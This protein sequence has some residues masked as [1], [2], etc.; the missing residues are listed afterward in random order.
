MSSLSENDVLET[1]FP[2]SVPVSPRT[3]TTSSTPARSQSPTPSSSSSSLS[4]YKNLAKLKKRVTSALFAT[5]STYNASSRSSS[6]LPS[7]TS[8]ASSP[9]ARSFSNASRLSATTTSAS[10]SGTATRVSRPRSQTLS[11]LDNDRRIKRDLPSQFNAQLHQISSLT[12]LLS[13]KLRPGSE[14]NVS[15]LQTAPKRQELPLALLDSQLPDHKED[16][17]IGEYLDRLEGLVSQKYIPFLLAKSNDNFH[18]TVLKAFCTRFEFTDEPIDMSLRKFLYVVQLPK[19][20]QQIDRVLDAFAERY[21]YC[22]PEI[23]VDKDQ[24]YVISFSL[25]ILHTDAFNK[26]NKHKMQRVE[27]VRNTRVDGVPS[28]ILEYFY[29]N[30]TY[31]MFAHENEDGDLPTMKSRDSFSLSSKAGVLIDP[32]SLIAERRIRELRPDLSDI[33]KSE[34]P[35]SYVGTAP[36]FDVNVLQGQFATGPVL[37][38]LPGRGSGNGSEYVKVVRLGMLM[39]LDRKKRRSGKAQWHRCGVVLSLTRMYLFKDVNWVR[40][41]IDQVGTDQGGKFPRVIQVFQADETILTKN[42]IA[43]LDLSFTRR[44]NVFVVVSQ[45]GGQDVFV[46]ESDSEMNDWISKLNY[47]AAL[48]SAGVQIIEDTGL[49]DPVESEKEEEV[50][51]QISKVK[52]ETRAGR[53]VALENWVGLLEQKLF[54]ASERLEDLY[55]TAKHFSVLTPILPRTREGVVIAARNVAK[56]IEGL[57]VDVMRLRCYREILVK[58]LDR[59]YQR[60][61]ELT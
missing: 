41:L 38:I 56:R 45:D 15:E 47:S 20:S 3:L 4:N 8:C 54:E 12:S 35:Y 49:P 25:M 53:C 58:E 55:R 28:E 60:T 36:Q 30:I 61:G 21:Q 5:N 1:K 44:Q 46:A 26:S 51:V 52:P 42:S 2:L 43:L 9:I 13:L 40:G 23:F 37:E 39:I 29:D 32:Y 22:N 19:E 7:G 59:D 33:L 6:E 18:E 10:A 11:S 57:R 16:E 50:G 27:Y 48:T 24:A 17:Q 31:A 14:A 34:N